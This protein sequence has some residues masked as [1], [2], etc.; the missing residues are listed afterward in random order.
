MGY[1]LESVKNSMEKLRPPSIVL[2]GVE[3]IGKSSFAAKMEKPIFIRTEDGVSN[4][5]VDTFPRC[6]KWEDVMGCMN[7]LAV[8]THS[9]E[10]A[11]I[12]SADWLERLIWEQVCRDENAASIEQASGG[13]G[14]GYYSALNYWTTYLQ[15]LDYLRDEK[16]MTICQIAHAKVKEIKAPDADTYDKYTLKIQDGRNTSASSLLFEHADIVLFANYQT[17]VVKETQGSGKNQQVIHSRAIGTGQRFLFTEE[18]PSF[19]AGNRYGLPDK[20]AFDKDGACW[21]TI[22][23]HI[24]YFVKK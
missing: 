13:Y 5:S 8:E 7:A 19:K 1:T 12:D 14:K 6:H 11:V 22:K 16:N 20:I 23:S 3:K 2:Y 24:P 9:Y 18:R 10:T 21:Q 17:N 4:I 15:C